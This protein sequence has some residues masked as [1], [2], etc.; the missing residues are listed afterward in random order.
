MLNIMILLLILGQQSTTVSKL[1]LLGYEQKHRVLSCGNLT[2]ENE[3]CCDTVWLEM[4]TMQH[5]I[6]EDYEGVYK[7]YMHI[8]IYVL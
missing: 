8:R 3:L 4:Q 5:E 2:T 6:K 1:A 7:Q